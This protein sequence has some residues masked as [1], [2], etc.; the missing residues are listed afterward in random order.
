MQQQT[1]A[2]RPL[3]LGY[4]TVV[5][6][7]CMVPVAAQR[8]PANQPPKAEM[9]DWA[10][11]T[12][13]EQKRV[14]QAIERGVAYLRRTQLSNGTWP[15][16]NPLEKGPR[17]RLSVGYAALAG[18]ALLEC[19][20]PPTDAT[21][22]KAAEF[23]RSSFT[24]NDTYQ[25]SLAIVFLDRLG[26][27]KDRPFICSLALRLVAGQRGGLNW[28]YVCPVL[29]ERQEKA[30]LGVLHKEQAKLVSKPSVAAP[31]E[32]LPKNGPE[33]EKNKTSLKKTG[34]PPLSVKN[35]QEMPGGDN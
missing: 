13:N 35:L 16:R 17:G 30:L 33:G 24:L 21:V 18:L 25:I 7:L 15:L 26:E 19:G 4:L 2:T 23:V 29:T 12:P 8:P 14:N 28:G 6:V 34:V 1:K 32:D 27:R 10:P 3:R 11:L 5:L 9:G 20:V 22:Q 31:P